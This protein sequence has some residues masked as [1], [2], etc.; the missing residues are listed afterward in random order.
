M[1]SSQSTSST[2]PSVGGGSE[3]V[4]ANSLSN[5][6]LY[7]PLNSL[8]ADHQTQSK[9]KGRHSLS[10][11][12]SSSL[13]ESSLVTFLTSIGNDLKTSHPQECHVYRG[14]GGSTGRHGTGDGGRAD[15]ALRNTIE[16]KL[17]NRS[18]VLV[19]G[20]IHTVKSPTKGSSSGDGKHTDGARSSSRKRKRVGGNGVF[21]CKSHRQRKR[22]LGKIKEE[23]KSR[24][25][26]TKP[27]EEL[28]DDV[29]S[30]VETLH[31][32]WNNYI[33]QI[34]SKLKEKSK[35]AASISL[36]VRTEI[37]AILATCEHIGMSATI[38]ACPSRRH[39]ENERCV[40]LNETNETFKI[41]II[42]SR[43]KSSKVTQT[44][45]EVT[46]TSK[47][48]LQWR[49]LIVPK[50]R[51]SLDISVSW[52]SASDRITVRLAS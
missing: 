16:S 4:G 30:I 1:M 51:T 42:K 33:Q 39:L 26:I 46:E 23:S 34:L 47:K 38:V 5:D 41:A 22:V 19:G 17:A 6:A 31:K 21:G 18:L 27:H 36:E 48:S 45:V 20:G 43:P 3:S 15:K 11:Q 8:Q 13:R 9:K 49:V 24:D 28:D 25:T 37:A 14:I 10:L 35:L 12:T 44:K 7:T 50:H 29:G 32:M 52:S 40:I 2:T